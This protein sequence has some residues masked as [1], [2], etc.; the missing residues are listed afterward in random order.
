MMSNND[1]QTTGNA[2][3]D[4]NSIDDNDR[5]INSMNHLRE[6]FIGDLLVNGSAPK[7]KEDRE[8]LIRLMDGAT[9]SSLAS[10]KIKADK[11]AIVSQAQQVQNLVEAV[12]IAQSR[13]SSMVN[14]MGTPMVPLMEPRIVPGITDIG[15]IPINTGNISGAQN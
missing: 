3:Q 12:R 10:K 14:G 6:K 4:E 7:D 2:T 1:L 11:E 9:R 15:Y 5:V 13:R 8:F